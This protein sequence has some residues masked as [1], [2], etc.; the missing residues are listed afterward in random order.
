MQGSPTKLGYLFFA[1][2]PIMSDIKDIT[3]NKQYE[4]P[5]L[6]GLCGA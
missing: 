5:E 2:L 3:R 1:I 6:T 4:R